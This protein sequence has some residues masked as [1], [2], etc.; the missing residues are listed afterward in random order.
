MIQIADALSTASRLDVKAFKKAVE[1]QGELIQGL[2]HDFERLI[3][4]YQ[5]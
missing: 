4:V 5:S 2:K 1:K 3:K